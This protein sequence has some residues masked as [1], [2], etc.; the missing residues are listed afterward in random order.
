MNNQSRLQMRDMYTETISS[1]L[2]ILIL[3]ARREEAEE[4]EEE[5]HEEQ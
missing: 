3:F 5:G 1:K 4:A 2:F